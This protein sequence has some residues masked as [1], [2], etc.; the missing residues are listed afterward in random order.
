MDADGA[1]LVPP[2]PRDAAGRAGAQG[3]LQRDHHRGGARADLSLHDGSLENAAGLL[4]S[5]EDC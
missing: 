1:R 5:Y 3:D 4:E 2:G